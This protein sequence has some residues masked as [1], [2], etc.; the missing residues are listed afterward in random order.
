MLGKHGLHKLGL[1]LL[2]LLAAGS[3]AACRG[4][5]EVITHTVTF[6]TFGGSDVNAQDIQNGRRIT[7]PADPTKEDGSEFVG[8]YK[9]SQFS[10]LW[11]FDIDIV[12]EPVTL[13]AQWRRIEPFPTEIAMT[14]TPFSSTVT[15]LQSGVTPGTSF[16]VTLTAGIPQVDVFGRTLYTYPDEGVVV[17]GSHQISDDLTITWSPD[18]PVQGGVY[19]IAILTDG[20]DEVTAVD[21]AFRGEG[22]AEN[23]FLV[24]TSID[25]A[26]MLEHDAIGAGQYYVLQNDLNREAAYASIQGKTFHGTFDGQNHT[27]TVTGNAGLFF[28]LGE[29]AVVENLI[30][31]GNVQTGTTPLIGGIAHENRGVIR[32]TVSWI[33]ITSSAGQVGNPDTKLEGGVGGLVGINHADGRIENCRFRSSGSSVGVLKANIG[34][35]GIA[36][37]NYG[38][39][40]RCENRGALG[41]F[42]A[43]ES[44][45]SLQRYS[46][47]GGIAG[48]NYGLIEQSNT[49]SVGKLLA[50]RYWNV[51]PPDGTENNRVIGGIAGYNGAE[52]II[53]E[54]F[55]NGIRVHGDQYVGGIA[56]INAGLI[57]HSYV[58]ARY[59]GALAGRSYVG[60]RS[61]VGGIAGAL[62]GEGR[63][64]Y[65]YAAI[66]VFAL[67]STPYANA[68]EA[69]N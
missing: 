5:D 29:T 53:R 68:S 26:G 60:G 28:A 44:G 49:T 11:N 39:I 32:D 63:V 38:T 51:S 17:A 48:F 67:E 54:S 8:W 42:N 62:Q 2:F 33:T 20:A 10:S 22:T 47:M 21:L 18:S 57:T 23:P 15:W 27:I 43:V 35:G 13:Y 61:D 55:F 52:G 25:L 1:A 19:K 59:Y 66:N 46:Y 12:T 7:R 64:E 45:R 34:A 24:F 37:I 4:E 31:D 16:E 9:D 56:G 36:S 65:S 69:Y 30:V 50:Q 40:S 58:G 3:L 6:E 41:A 14:P